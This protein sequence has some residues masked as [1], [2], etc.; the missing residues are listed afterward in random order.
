[1]FP[2]TLPISLTLG[3]LSVNALKFTHEPNECRF[4]DDLR[5][6]TL[7]GSKP[8]SS[9]DSDLG[10]NGLKREPERL[11]NVRTKPEPKPETSDEP[12]G[13]ALFRRGPEPEPLHYVRRTERADK[14][15]LQHVSSTGRTLIPTF[16]GSSRPTK[17]GQSMPTGPGL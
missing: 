8:L 4:L 15:P 1:M 5:F 13:P 10:S 11:G 9:L 14:L 16:S 7:S 17:P 6:R 12:E 3:V 2:R